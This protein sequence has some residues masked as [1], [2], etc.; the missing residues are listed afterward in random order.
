ME[1]G[2]S[3]ETAGSYRER[4]EAQ[5]EIRKMSRKKNRL[6]RLQVNRYNT[7]KPKRKRGVNRGNN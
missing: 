1:S 4:T 5:K 2:G 7:Q 3:S 6:K